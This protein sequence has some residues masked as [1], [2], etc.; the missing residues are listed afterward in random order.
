METISPER[1]EELPRAKQQI[2]CKEKETAV[3][4]PPTHSLHWDGE[5]RT[6]LSAPPP[7]SAPRLWEASWAQGQGKAPNIWQPVN[8]ILP[9]WGLG[10]L[11]VFHFPFPTNSSRGV[12]KQLDLPSCV[13]LWSLCPAPN[14]AR[15]RKRKRTI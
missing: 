13:F 8:L 3:R 14:P 12:G 9:G 2:S 10:L 4:K 6:G 5:R 1:S 7:P 15:K 11:L